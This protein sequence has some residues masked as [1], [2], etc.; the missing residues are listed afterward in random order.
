MTAPNIVLIHGHDLGVWLSCYGMPSVPSPHLD[1]FADESVTFESAFAAA[2]LC[3]PARSSIFTGLL[4]H[5]NGLM[6]LTH[7]GWSYR[8]GVT[9]LPEHLRESGYHSTLIGL[10]HEDFDARALGYDEVHGLGFLPRALE[11]A[12]RV[13]WWLEQPERAQSEQPHLLTIGM[14]EAHRPWPTEDYEHADPDAVDVPGYLPDT[15]DTREDI[16]GFHGAIRQL[17]EAVGRILTAIDDSPLADNTLVIFTTDHG[18]AFP[19]AKST[20]YDSGVQVALMM[21]PPRTWGV[22]P[23][24]SEALV[25]HLDL[26]PTCI[27]LAGGDVPDVLE[28]RS[29]VQDLRGEENITDRDLVLE[30]TFHDRYDPIRALRTREAKYIRNYAPGP[31]HPLAIDLEESPTRRSLELD[32]TVP[33]ELYLLGDDLD[34]LHNL[35]E[36]R[37]HESLR[38]T[39]AH[40]LDD[41]LARTGDPVLTGDVPEP[42]PPTRAR[43]AQAVHTAQ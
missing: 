34:E 6:G 1:R 13:E 40:R 11:V 9:T 14:W 23:R 16:A 43:D 19:R 25:S 33:E 35:A 21:R 37:R 28:G 4:P 31:R 30:K 2:P 32:A 41:H 15:A 24:R 36:D 20:L 29:L 5:Q 27:E 38:R 42:A 18:A 10:Q 26:V 8:D 39:L 17:D 12:H 7:A 22:T 3:T